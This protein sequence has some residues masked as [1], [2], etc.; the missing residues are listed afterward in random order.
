MQLLQRWGALCFCGAGRCRG[1]MSCWA[2]A[3]L[4][5]LPQHLQEMLQADSLHAAR[6]C[7]HSAV[8]L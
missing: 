7:A 1:I 2:Y 3:L 4:L 5:Q 8:T 6:A